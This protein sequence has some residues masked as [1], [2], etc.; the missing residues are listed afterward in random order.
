MAVLI[1][2]NNQGPLLRTYAEYG[3]EHGHRTVGVFD[4]PAAARQWLAAHPHP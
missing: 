1:D 3:G 4:D 2:G